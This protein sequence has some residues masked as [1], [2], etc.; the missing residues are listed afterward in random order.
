VVSEIS[1]SA[2]SAAGIQISTD[3]VTNFE[4]KIRIL[5]SSYTDLSS[6]TNSPFLT[7]MSASVEIQTETKRNIACLP[8]EAVSTR[9]REFADSTVKSSGSEDELDEVVFS[10]KEGKAVKHIVTTGIQDNRYIEVLTGLD[11]LE[12]VV[13]G[14]YV[15]ISKKLDADKMV[16]V[17]KKEEISL[18]EE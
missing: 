4:V 1:K 15:A 6:T 16:I 14:P 7:G 12:K 17:K 2:S 9:K 13:V 11:G 8:I 18:I 3:Q 10:I 5:K